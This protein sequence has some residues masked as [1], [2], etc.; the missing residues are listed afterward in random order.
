MTE[1]TKILTDDLIDF[2]NALEA[3][4]IKL[5]SQIQRL[6]SPGSSPGLQREWSWNPERIIWEL[7]EG[8][9]GTYQKTEELTNPEFQAMLTDL[10]AHQNKLSRDGYFYWT[11]QNGTTVGRKKT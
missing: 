11:F 1:E 7:S 8:W 10:A 9:K 4:V 5:R 2:C 3:S 6:Y